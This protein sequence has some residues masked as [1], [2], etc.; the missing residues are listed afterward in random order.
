MTTVFAVVGEHHDD[1]DRLLL[2]GADGQH[3]QFLLQEGTT[4]PVV[5]DETWVIDPNPP[6][7]DEVVSWTSQ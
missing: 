6:P 2:L 4:T 1:P 3:Y 5:P 7:P